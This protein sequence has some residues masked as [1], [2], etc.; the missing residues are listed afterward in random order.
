[1]I[2]TDPTR[3]TLAAALGTESSFGGVG[4]RQNGLLYTT[5]G[6]NTWIQLNNPLL[7][8]ELDQR[9]RAAT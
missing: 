6:G 7:G 4:V 2:L 5:N 3:Q 1:M 8:T 9:G